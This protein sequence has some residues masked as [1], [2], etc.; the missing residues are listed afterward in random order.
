MLLRHTGSGSAFTSD[1][2]EEF[3]DLLRGEIH[4]PYVQVSVSR[5]GGVENVAIMLRAS[6]EPEEE[7]TNG[8]FHNS[9][10]IILHI[11]NYG[12]I[13]LA[14]DSGIKSEWRPVLKKRFRKTKFKSWGEAIDKINSYLKEAA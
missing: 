9:R 11:K 4:A 1:N 7:W 5:L 14:G 12:E 13:T 10:Y 3:A 2:A 6:L 8:I